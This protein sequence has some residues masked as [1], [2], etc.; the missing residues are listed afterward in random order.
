M[1][2]ASTAARRVSLRRKVVAC[3]V[4]VAAVGSTPAL[5]RAQTRGNTAATSHWPSFRGANAAGVI[6]G[7]AAPAVWNVPEKKGV[8]WKTPVPGLGHSS[9][10]VWGDRIFVTTAVSGKPDAGLKVGL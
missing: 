8:L 4:A 10:V 9:P 1:P 5:L 6:E 3:L 2:A 7:F